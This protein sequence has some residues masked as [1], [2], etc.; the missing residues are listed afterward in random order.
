[1]SK[2]Y[3]Y[4][5][6]PFTQKW[7]VIHNL[8]LSNTPTLPL[9]FLDMHPDPNHPLAPWEFQ[10]VDSTSSGSLSPWCPLLTLLAHILGSVTPGSHIYH[11]RQRL[12]IGDIGETIKD[13]K[14][15]NDITL[16]Q[17]E[18]SSRK[19][20]Q[21]QTHKIEGGKTQSDK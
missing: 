17:K 13:F 11:K 5:P 4:F 12:S 10:S 1:M 20:K 16:N 15:N 7:K 18:C 3:I 9:I 14:K 8:D 21:K 19:Q 2:L 6:C